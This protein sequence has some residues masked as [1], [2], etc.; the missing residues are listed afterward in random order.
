MPKLKTVDRLRTPSH[1]EVDAASMRSGISFADNAS[2]MAVFSAAGVSDATSSPPPTQNGRPGTSATAESTGQSDKASTIR[3][4]T[5]GKGAGDGYDT[6][7]SRR[8]V[9]RLQSHQSQQVEDGSLA[10]YANSMLVPDEPRA[11]GARLEHLRSPS[12]VAIVGAAGVV[13]V[14]EGGQADPAV[15]NDDGFQNEQDAQNHLDSRNANGVRLE[16]IRSPSNIAIVGAAG[17]IGV[18]KGGEAD[19]EVPNDDGFVKEKTPDGKAHE[20]ELVIGNVDG[21]KNQENGAGRP[22]MYD[23]T[24]TEFQTAI[25]KI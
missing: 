6:P 7:A 17:T 8:S 1:P 18:V 13:D 21:S 25:E 23:R 4:L 14:V 15:E 19:P 5:I 16:H 9:E 3:S 12:N 20:R 11:N 22:G 10:S 24:N 2:T